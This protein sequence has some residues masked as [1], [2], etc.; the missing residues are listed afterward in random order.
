MIKQNL[1]DW[2][3]VLLNVVST[4]YQ[5]LVNQFKFL[6]YKN[7]VAIKYFNKYCS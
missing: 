2:Y 7:R 5:E 1:I 6:L 3:V 4:N